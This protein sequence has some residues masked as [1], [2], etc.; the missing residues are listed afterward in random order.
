MTTIEQ[1]RNNMESFYIPTFRSGKLLERR[2]E[3]LDDVWL[4]VSDSEQWSG[5]VSIVA[6]DDSDDACHIIN[7]VMRSLLFAPGLNNIVNSRLLTVSVAASWSLG[8]PFDNVLMDAAK[9]VQLDP[10]NIVARKLLGAIVED[11]DEENR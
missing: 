7:S 5:L 6:Q 11:F 2:E 4:V 8:A 10:D 3:L 9:A 1:F